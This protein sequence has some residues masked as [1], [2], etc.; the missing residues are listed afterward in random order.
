M[1]EVYLTDLGEEWNGAVRLP[2]GESLCIVVA[3]S[4]VPQP[5][6]IKRLRRARLSPGFR[7]ENE[8][9]ELDTL[10]SSSTSATC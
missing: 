8:V 2:R 3:T 6:F 9:L 4:S 7:G 10:R 1:T 5:V